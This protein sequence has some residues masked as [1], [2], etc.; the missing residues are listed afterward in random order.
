MLTSCPDDLQGPIY[1]F[2]LITDF[3]WSS[4]AICFLSSSF[5]RLIQLLSYL[6]SHNASP[7]SARS[8][9][10]RTLRLPFPYQPAIE[11]LV[12]WYAERDSSGVIDTFTPLL[13]RNQGYSG[14]LKRR[15][16]FR[17]PI[18]DL[19]V[20]FLGRQSQVRA[21]WKSPHEPPSSD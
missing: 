14:V 10:P 4:S 1:F 17:Q 9:V 16:L 19:S 12:Q 3:V 18:P 13:R 21:S 2:F 8:S 6:N 7:H 15:S 20:Q 11:I 5:K